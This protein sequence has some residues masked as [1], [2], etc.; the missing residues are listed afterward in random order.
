MV[1]RLRFYDNLL[2]E[3][4]ARYRQMAFVSGPRQVGKTT[5]CRSVATNYFNWDAPD[6]RR[7]ILAGPD[8]LAHAIDLDVAHARQPVV[9]LDELH[10]YAKW[11]SFLKGFFDVYEKRLKI[12]V[13]GS[14]RLDVYR[15]GSDSLMGRYF[16]FRMHPWS[17]AEAVATSVP[18]KLGREPKAIND[19]DWQAL[20][21]HGGF[22]EPFLTRDDR[23]TQRWRS[24]RADQLSKG[25]L[26]EVTRI[27]EL[28]TLEVLMELLAEHSSQQLIYNNYAKQLGVTSQTIKRWVNLLNRMHYGF[29]LLPWFKSIT[30][31]LRKEPKWFL[32]DWSGIVDDGPR[33]ETFVGCH[34]LKAVEGWTDLGLGE[35]EL[36]YIRTALGR[37]VDF[38]VIR[39]R[40]PWMLVEAKADETSLSPGLHE[41][42]KI[43]KT[44]YAFQV[45]LNLSYEPV[46]CF[47]YRTPVAVPARTFLSCQRRSE[48]AVN[49]PV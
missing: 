8:S 17:V 14:S 36:R 10:K 37:E 22:P 30:R 29:S 33:V 16:L 32:R 44:E 26:R 47:S 13:T 15:R 23:F 19:A 41:F 12:A 28:G 7:V 9:V 2:K 35:F 11:K 18:S 49:P 1:E 25:D 20:L 6:D 5:T 31:A 24:R 38:L 42:Q 48:N 43:L 21:R 27:E 45:V 34:L 39:D 46:D 4:F 3:H 40:K